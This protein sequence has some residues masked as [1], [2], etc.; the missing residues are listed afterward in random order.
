MLIAQEFYIQR[1]RLENPNLEMDIGKGPTFSRPKFDLAA[2]AARVE[3]V[4]S[5]IRHS[6]L[7][8]CPDEHLPLHGHCHRIPSAEAQCRNP[9]THVAADHFVD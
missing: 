4:P 6:K 8:A 3:L 9:A 5:P 1:S 2:L 7:R